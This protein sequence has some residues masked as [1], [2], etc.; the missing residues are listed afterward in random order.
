MGCA[1]YLP[2]SSFLRTLIASRTCER[3]RP[4][5]LARLLRVI[6]VPTG[7]V[8]SS[9][10]L[11]VDWYA[12]AAALASCASAFVRCIRSCLIG[13][14]FMLLPPFCCQGDHPHSDSDLSRDWPI[15]NYSLLFKS[16]LCASTLNQA[17]FFE[18]CLSLRGKRCLFSLSKQMDFLRLR[19][20]PQTR[21]FPSRTEA[22][23]WAGSV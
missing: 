1:I 20:F 11:S 17:D 19:I 14:P 7:T 2:H 21:S 23:T 4:L 10:W 12:G 8:S 15:C 13:L 6:T 5:P 16:V 22:K 3:P 18:R 9:R